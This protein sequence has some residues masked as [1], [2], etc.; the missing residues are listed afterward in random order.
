MQPMRRGSVSERSMKCNKP[1]CRCGEDPKARHGPHY[2]LTRGVGGETRSRYLSEPQAALAREQIG[3][4][5]QFRRKV[6]AF[7]QGCEEWADQELEGSVLA[8]ASAEAE[9]RGLSTT[10]QNE[11]AQEIEFLLG[12]Q[13]IADLDLEAVEMAVRRQALRL[14]A[15]ALEQRLNA[16]ASDYTGPELACPCGAVAQYRDRHERSFI[17]ALGL[18]RLKRAYYHCDHC[19]SG[20]CPRDRMLGLEKF[21]LTP[22]VVRMTGSTGALV[23]FEESRGLLHELAG[24]EVSAKQ[25]E[26]VAEALGAKIARDER[27]QVERLGCVAPTLYLGMDGAGAPMRPEQVA[28]RAGKQPDGWAKTREAKLVTIWSAESRDEQ[29]RPV[30]DPGSV[31]Y[32]AAIETSATIDT[33][34]KLLEFA[35]RV[36]RE[37]A[38]RGF[39]EASRQVVLGDGSAWIWN[40]AAELFPQGIQ[41]LDQFHAK[42]HLGTVGKLIYGDGNEGKQWIHARYEELDSGAAPFRR[43]GLTRPRPPVQRSARLHALC[44]EQPRAH[45]LPEIPRSRP[46][47]GHWRGRSR[48]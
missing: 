32:S 10:F 26:R 24:V 20:F 19:H 37:A 44:L 6:E 46:V 30:H 15:Q 28:G 16:D 3:A 14:A 41:S 27:Q 45:A 1:G 4:G 12:R 48:L 22:A 47:H 25:V 7:W 34:P 33:S 35:E 38:R 18:L 31:T 21:S 11:I 42:E 5:R 39:N 43:P 2:S 40:T 36:S 13:S 23:S 29:G 17:S 8:A 9:K